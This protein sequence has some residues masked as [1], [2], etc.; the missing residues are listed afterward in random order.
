[1]GCT[2]TY[3]G[4]NCYSYG[5]SVNTP[6]CPTNET[7]FGSDVAD[8]DNI[9]A[10]HINDLR[11][12]VDNERQNRREL[13]ADFPTYVDEDDTILRTHLE[14]LRDSI[15]EMVAQSGDSVTTSITDTYSNKISAA[16]INSLRTKL[17]ALRIYLC[18]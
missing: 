3:C 7:N 16:E 9:L 4:G 6:A 5:C 14:D 2:P 13:A 18:C 11:V 8:G 17:N 10:S 15:N 12:S 1:M